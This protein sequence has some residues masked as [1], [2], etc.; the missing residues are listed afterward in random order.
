MRKQIIKF[1][2]LIVVFLLIF[3][4]NAVFAQKY[5]KNSFPAF[6]GH[7]IFC[8]SNDKRISCRDLGDGK[9]HSCGEFGA[10]GCQALEGSNN[11][12]SPGCL[13][14]CEKVSNIPSSDASNLSNASNATH[15]FINEALAN[16]LDDPDSEWIELFNNGSA[17]VD[18]TNWNISETASANFTLSGII[19]AKGFVILTRNVQ[20]FNL[21]YP[22][23]SLSAI[24][25]I[26]I[27]TPNFN[28]ADASGEILLYNASGALADR[29]EYAQAAGKAFENISIGRYPDGSPSIINLTIPSPGARNDA[30]APKLNK[31]IN[32]SANS[33]KV[34]ALINITV[35]IT[36]DTTPVNSTKINLNGTE[37]QMSSNG[38]IWTFLWNTS[39]FA[40]GQYNIT[41]F[42]NDSYGKSGADTLFNIIVNNSP[43]VTA[44]SPANLNI[45]IP[46]GFTQ[47]FSLD[48]LDPDDALLNF[49]WFID[50]ILNSTN[51]KNF[52]YTPSFSDNG[53]HTVNATIRDSSS[54]QISI[55]W[56]AIV[57]NFNRAPVLDAISSKAVNK[58]SNLAFN[59]TATDLDNDT[60]AF[61][62]NRSGITITKINNSVATVSFTPTNLDLGSNIVNLIASD[63]FLTDSKIVVITV[64]AGSN[65][66]PIITSSPIT[67]GTVSQLYNYDADALDL[68]TDILIFSLASNATGMVINSATGLISFTPASI[69]VFAVNV[70]VS[71]LVAINSQ[72]YTLIV[73]NAS[74]SLP[75]SAINKSKLQI[76]DVD[77]KIDGK[78]RSNLKDN[79]K[80]SRE[81]KPG[82][83]IEFK[84]T[85]K[86]DFTDSEDIKIEDIAVRTTIE[87]IDND[88]DLEEESKEFDLRA[89]SDKTV[90]FKFEVPLNVE[91]GDYN[92][93]IEAEGEDENGNELDDD[94]EVEIEVEKE[95]HDLRFL[96]FDLKPETISCNREFSLDYKVINAGQE[97]ESN[98]AAGIKS[99]DLGLDLFEK[100]ISVDAGTD[101]NIFS[102]ARRIKLNRSIESGSYA[103]T[104]D[105]YS[106]DGILQDKKSETIKV[107]D[108][109]KSS[110]SKED[111][112]VLITGADE[113]RKTQSMRQEI[114]ISP[115]KIRSSDSD[116]NLRLLALSTF[117]FAGFFVVVAILLFFGF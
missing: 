90:T 58:N 14:T 61:S 34:G 55:K 56:T 54:N 97:D 36:D 72:S 51:P 93:F 24:S 27:T 6:N 38:E 33:T 87:E 11:G 46:E 102:G 104:A 39:A 26:N 43:F 64:N 25:I 81:A 60:L 110:E 83:S 4:V 17:D 85:V 45:T 37:F 57:T 2:L 75:S 99:A 16:G 30:Q 88:D 59:I 79:S 101:N 70:S 28:L 95:K 80:I 18:L 117:I 114:E 89:Q 107:E 19:P 42:F 21:T 35:N 31:W 67:S 5:I 12:G 100:G 91:E 52:S 115:V 82:S 65:N 116:R 86:N 108:C 49:F 105:L 47:Q 15:V 112:V 20:L 50:N 48:A 22:K 68:D 76:I 10:N 106:E 77:A 111:E 84:V 40:Q 92:V 71:D 69:G 73:S 3:T 9:S 98:S 74:I 41:V 8:D 94:F 96:N 109:I 62:S 23:V 32:P 29:F 103:I 44:F 78:K 13:I 1:K 66:A 63:G 53:T 113:S 7:V